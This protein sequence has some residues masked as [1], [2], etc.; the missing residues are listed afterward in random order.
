MIV[1]DANLLLYAY[2]TAFPEH[3]RARAWVERVFYGT[4]LVG[5]PWQ[6]IS[7]FLRVATSTRLPGPRFNIQEAIEIVNGWQEQPNVR[8]LS[9]GENH[10]AVLQQALL[11]GRASG[12]LV[13]DA[14]LAAITIEYGGVL[15]TTDH[16]FARF[17]GLRWMNPLA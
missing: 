11:Q 13:S 10:W 16:D 14:A 17:P 9:P 4:E 12:V 1:F 6:T 8:L 3:S 15:H 5:L 2:D 7:A